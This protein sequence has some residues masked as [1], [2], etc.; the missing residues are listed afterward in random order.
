MDIRHLNSKD[1]SD[2]VSVNQFNKLIRTIQMNDLTQHG[3]KRVTEY[4]QTLIRCSKSN[5][6]SRYQLIIQY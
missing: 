2:N 4:E 5:R 3:D 6:I 1:I